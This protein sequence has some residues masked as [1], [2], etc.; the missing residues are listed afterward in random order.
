MTTSNYGFKKR[1]LGHPERDYDIGANLDMIDTEIKARE[2]ETDGITVTTNT[3]DVE[4]ATITATG[5]TKINLDGPVDLTGKLTMDSIVAGNNLAIAVKGDATGLEID[6]DNL[7]G[8]ELYPELPAAGDALT[9]GK[10]AKGVWTRFL[11][12]KA[13]TNCVTIVG[14]EA[15]IRVK[16]NL[17]DGV[18]AGLW[19][20]F[21]Q[22]G[23]VALASP[24]V[25]CGINVSVEG[26]A[27]LTV[28]SGAFLSG[29]CIDSSVNDSAT[30]T[31]NFDGIDIKTSSSMEKW[32]KGISIR[33]DAAVIGMDI[34]AC[35]TGINFSG[36]CTNAAISMNS[37]TFAALDNEIEMRNTVSGDKTVIA[38]GAA[39]ADADIRTAV[40]ADADIADGSLYLSVVTGAGKLFCKQNSV[41]TDISTA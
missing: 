39:A 32:K 35:T 41:W 12:N 27:G 9:A 36:A 26:S 40:G 29:I 21:E 15:Q 17:G 24:G 10:V 18:H 33:D 20:Y 30:V 3:W 28:A 1:A 38:S 34:G 6:D 16:A 19:A 13:Q 8:I 7:F 2:D 11:V 31:G 4:K 23:T 37:A 25:N 22:S 5:A 14:H